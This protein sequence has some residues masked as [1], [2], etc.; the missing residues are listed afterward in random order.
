M[1]SMCSDVQNYLGSSCRGAVETKLT[2]IHKDTVLIPGFPQWVKGP[3]LLWLWCRPVAVAPIQ[4]LV[5]EHQYAAGV[6]L[7]KDKTKQ[8]TT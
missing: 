4:P 3:V 1:L 6:A 8:K 2:S 7:K 5:W